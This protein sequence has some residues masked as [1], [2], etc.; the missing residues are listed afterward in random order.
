MVAERMGVVARARTSHTQTTRQ[1]ERGARREA[2]GELPLLRRA[3]RWSVGHSR[4]SFDEA[5]FLLPRSML[6]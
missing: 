3:H 1:R 6:L 5:E 4:L 2:R